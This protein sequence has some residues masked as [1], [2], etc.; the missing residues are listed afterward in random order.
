M[1][2]ITCG[3]IAICSSVIPKNYEDP[4]RVLYDRKKEQMLSRKCSHTQTDDALTMKQ[5][6]AIADLLEKHGV[7]VSGGASSALCSMSIHSAPSVQSSIPLTVG[8][9]ARYYPWQPP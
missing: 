6:L 4:Y 8:A 2:N 3:D 7:V 9:R 5:S 1:L